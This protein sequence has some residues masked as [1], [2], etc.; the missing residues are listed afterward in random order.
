MC[1]LMFG[2]WCPARLTAN[3][4]ATS[5]KHTPFVLVFSRCLEGWSNEFQFGAQDRPRKAQKA[6]TQHFMSLY[7]ATCRVE[8][9]A[10]A[11]GQCDPLLLVF[12]VN[13][14]CFFLNC[15]SRVFAASLPPRGWL[16]ALVCANFL[17]IVTLPLFSP[18]PPPSGDIVFSPCRWD[19][20][21]LRVC[22]WTLMRVML[23]D[24]LGIRKTIRKYN[25]AP[26]SLSTSLHKPFL[27]FTYFLFGTFRHLDFF[28]T[29]MFEL[30]MDK[31]LLPQMCRKVFFDVRRHMSL[32]SRVSPSRTRQ[33]SI[34]MSL[35]LEC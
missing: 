24:P 21:F 15:G 7:F 35:H 1:A 12:S 27:I 16:R 17:P 31:S 14:S 18:L 28:R 19:L 6:E 2:W 25:Q 30:G 13:I 23:S 32:C 11:C 3:P 22:S 9:V 5:E 4:A 34:A 8:R 20:T 26:S 33:F 10:F 29:L